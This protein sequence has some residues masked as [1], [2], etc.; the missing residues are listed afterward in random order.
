MPSYGFRGF[1]GLGAETTWGTGVAASAY[2]ELLSESMVTTQDRFEVKNVFAGMSEPDDELGVQ[3]HE[4]D[5]VLIAN[6]ANVGH[7]FKG[8]MGLNS[9]AVILSG[10]LFRNDFT[11]VGTDIGSFNALPAYTAEIFRD[12]TSSDRFSG[13]Q[14]NRMEV[15]V[16]P[17]QG[18][19][20]TMGCLAR[21]HDI[22]AKT[23][24]TFPGS[25]LGTFKFDTC[26]IG[27]GGVGTQRFESF[28]LTIDNQL[29]SIW[30]LSGSASIAK[31]H[32]TG[33][34]LVRISGTLELDDLAEYLTFQ[35][36][37]ENRLTMN[38][39]RPSSFTLLFDMP[40]VILTTYPHKNTGRDRLTVDFEGKCR[41]HTGS[42]NA[43]KVS[44]TTINT[45]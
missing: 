19:Q 32:R 7:F 35:A 30:T 13:L 20:V 18:V 26:S 28:R 36:Q 8:N 23:T 9:V 33:P 34:Q 2:F 10:F 29:Q 11:L 4:G 14:M 1:L 25:P 5:I 6:P 27:F 22:I 38:I 24:P 41:F 15:S 39:T 44:L 42:A 45:F 40:R 16:Q 17:N 12:V 43:I 3:R 21:Y 31:A 37:T